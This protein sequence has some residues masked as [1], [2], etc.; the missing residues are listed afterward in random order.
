LERGET[1][2]TLQ[3]MLI[4]AHALHTTIEELLRDVER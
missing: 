4:L 2:P 1:N 3:T